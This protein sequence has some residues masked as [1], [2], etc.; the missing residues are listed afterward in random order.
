[1]CALKNIFGCVSMK[2]KYSILTSLGSPLLAAWWTFNILP[3]VCIYRPTLLLKNVN[4]LFPLL[5]NSPFHLPAYFV[6]IFVF[7]TLLPAY[8]GHVTCPAHVDLSRGWQCIIP[9]C[10]C[11]RLFHGSSSE[12]HM[13]VSTV[14][15]RHSASWISSV[16]SVPCWDSL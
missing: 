4:I 15:C 5:C 6:D 9:A 7:V 2:C 10:S 3:S 16:I 11:S 1:M 13:G 12:R 14:L 8:C